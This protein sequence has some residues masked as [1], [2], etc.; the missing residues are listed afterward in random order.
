MCAQP[1]MRLRTGRTRG[2]EEAQIRK[3]FGRLEGRFNLL[4]SLPGLF[5]EPDVDRIGGLGLQPSPAGQMSAQARKTRPGPGVLCRGLSQPPLEPGRAWGPVCLVREPGTRMNR[6][7]LGQ[8]SFETAPGRE[9]VRSAL[10]GRLAA[11]RSRRGAAAA[12]PHAL[13]GAASGL[14]TS[15][16]PRSLLVT[17]PPPCPTPGKRRA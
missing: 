4:P 5:I 12:P 10:T 6:D 3:R 11:A 15:N 2:T 9:G 7:A 13:G 8:S 1:H 14:P 17:T 16:N